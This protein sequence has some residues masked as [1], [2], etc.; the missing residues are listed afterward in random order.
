MLGFCFAQ[1]VPAT[2]FAV[3]ANIGATFQM[4]F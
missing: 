4:M 3:S 1:Q 2:T